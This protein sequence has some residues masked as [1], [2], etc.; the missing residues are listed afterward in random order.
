MSNLEHMMISF[1]LLLAPVAACGHGDRNAA[2]PA[3][4]TAQAPAAKPAP[5]PPPVAKAPVA[6]VR[7]FLDKDELYA[8]DAAV[9]VAT[10][11]G[12]VAVSLL[13]EDDDVI[14]V[15]TDRGKT[16]DLERHSAA[17]GESF[18]LFSIAD[19]FV[20]VI[21]TPLADGPSDVAV[22]ESVWAEGEGMFNDIRK[23]TSIAG[24]DPLPAWVPAAVRARFASEHPVALANRNP[25]DAARL[26]ALAN[27]YATNDHAV[28]H[29]PDGRDHALEIGLLGTDAGEVQLIDATDG[30]RVV[31]TYETNV[32]TDILATVGVE[33]DGKHVIFAASEQSGHGA[34]PEYVELGWKGASLAVVAHAAP[35][36]P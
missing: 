7:T 15:A 30:H 13:R 26:A 14:V 19:G 22:T 23:A 18:G 10:A 25:G 16:T 32:V 9:H 27:R 24:T 36:A 8:G 31:A 2:P 11:H 20:L 33:P 4:T 29:G 17:P 34:N 6:P 21:A 12:D 28:I 35:D 5:A 1:A 3:P